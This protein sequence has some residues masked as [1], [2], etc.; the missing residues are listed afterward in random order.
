[1]QSIKSP[2]KSPRLYGITETNSS[3]SGDDL[4]GKNQFNSTFPLAL[5]L[6]MRDDNVSPV[7]VILKENRI[8]TNE[9]KWSMSQIVGKS[10]NEPFYLFEHIYEP[11][12]KI[13]RNH[14]FD[15][16]DLVVQDKTKK[17]HSFEIKLTVIPDLS[18]SKLPEEKWG[19][20]IVIRPVSS[21]HAMMGI[22]T[23][24][25]KNNSIKLEVKKALKQV[26]NIVS[27]WGNRSEILNNSMKLIESLNTAL[28]IVEPLQQPFLIQPLWKTRGQSFIL[29]ENCFD[30]FVWSDAAILKLPILHANPNRLDRFL[31]EVARHIKALYE[32]LSMGDYNYTKIYKNM[33]LGMQTDKAFS[34]SGRKSSKYLKHK[35]LTNPIYPAN[36]LGKI[37]VN[38][39]ENMLKPERRFDAAVQLYMSR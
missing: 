32:I 39:G 13:M 15:K 5:C 16:I 38:G 4:W 27:D 21:A 8:S 3:R 26:Y 30:V 22:A 6:Y 37:V 25:L 7:S 12:Q 18:T 34:I 2:F 29:S 14:T 17:A 23:S 36:L 24:I 28:S 11:Y 20:E 1:M 31:R 33:G 35:R 9:N 10:K 19:P